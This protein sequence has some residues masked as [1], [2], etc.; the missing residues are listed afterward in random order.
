MEGETFANL[1]N[2][3]RVGKQTEEDLDTL[4]Y[5]PAEPNS[6]DYPRDVTHIFTFNNNINKHN[7]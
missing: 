4:R 6:P 7:V 2:R 3:I 5:P 1:L